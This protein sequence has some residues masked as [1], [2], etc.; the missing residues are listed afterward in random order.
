M[1]ANAFTLDVSQ[2]STRGLTTGWLLLALASLVMGGLFA[3]LLV[4]SRAPDFHKII[5]W[6][7]FF[8]TALIVHVNMT[9]LVWF[10]AFAGVFWSL[11]ITRC[12][13]CGWIA[14]LLSIIGTFIITLAPFIGDAFPLMNNYVPVL[15]TPIFFVGLSIFGLGFT[16]LVLHGLIGSH[17]NLTGDG[18]SALRFGLFTALLAAFIAI[19]ALFWSYIGISSKT[20]NA[21]HYYELLF[22]GS[23]HVVQ[24]THT[25][26]M[27]VAWLWLATISG[28]KLS[29]TPRVAI[30]LFALGIAPTLLTPFIYL[31][32]EVNF[33]YHQ[34]AFTW[35]MQYGG[36]LAALPL[37]LIVVLG[38]IKGN[39]TTTTSDYAKQSALIFSILLFG[40]GGIIGFL[41]SGSN[42]IIPAHYHG[43]I[44]AVT[45]AFMG[46]TYHLMPRLGF[47]E[48]TGKWVK[49][50]PTIYGIGQLLHALGLAW[51]GGHGVQRKTAGTAQGLEGFQQIAGMRVMEIGGLLAIVGGI[52]FLVVVFLAMR[53]QKA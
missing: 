49:W 35:L 5:P 48:L 26:L 44:G 27:L 43:S 16:V 29:V 3:I 1:K 38:L 14:L 21:Q 33:G 40:V 24:F 45:I 53:P 13:F 30:F 17:V 28:A 46:I 8:H 20:L 18:A 51:S 50:Q 47:R 31:T 23:G 34:V 37:G 6:I 42:V 25:Q 39:R 19:V 2:G 36:G 10:L 9:V 41:I 11:M 22:W 7:D 52:I 12:L 32:Y 15:Q 4:L